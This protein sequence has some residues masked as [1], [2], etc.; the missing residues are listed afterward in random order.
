MHVKD[1]KNVVFKEEEIKSDFKE[2]KKWAIT[3]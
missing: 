2:I 3:Y 1:K